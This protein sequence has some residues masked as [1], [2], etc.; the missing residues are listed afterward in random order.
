[1]RL[2]ETGEAGF[3][4]TLFPAELN[5]PAANLQTAAIVTA[6][7]ANRKNGAASG[8]DDSAAISKLRVLGK[9]CHA[10]FR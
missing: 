1:M 2:P 4:K 5:S 3:A 8:W 10:N 7:A 6:G 9:P